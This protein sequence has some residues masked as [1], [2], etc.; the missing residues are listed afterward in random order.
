MRRRLAQMQPNRTPERRRQQVPMKDKLQ[1]LRSKIDELDSKL[2]RLLNERTKLVLEIGKIKHTSGGEV[3][4]P[5]REDAVLRRIVGKGE[6]PLPA[7]SLRAIYREVMSASLALE[8]A[9]L[10]AYLGPEAS[11]SHL[12]VI[13]KFGSSLKYEPLPSI[14][15]VF[16]EVSKDRA[17]YGGVPIENSTEGAVTHTYDMFLDSEL[18]ICAQIVLPIRHNL[19]AAVAR[20]QI[21]KIYSIPQVLSQCRQWLH[22]N[23][24]HAELIETS[25]STRAAQIAKTEPNAGALASSLAADMYGLTILE[26]NVQDSSENVTRF[27]VIGGRYAGRTGSDKTSIMF[28]VQDHVD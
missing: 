17:D 12:A 5:D 6:G 24:P 16:M 23:M 26:A 1:P 4:A 7:D 9:L 11:Y 25:S 19:M 22:L 15:N 10:I 28:S 13:K 8:K 2:V 27:L 14:N 21:K 3:Y 18:K 20:D